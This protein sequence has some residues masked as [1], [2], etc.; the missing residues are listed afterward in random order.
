MVANNSDKFATALI[1]ALATIDSRSASGSNIASSS[2][3]TDTSTITFVAGFT[4]GSWIGDLIAS[5]FNSGLTGVSTTP[6]WV[7]SQTFRSYGTG[8]AYGCQRQFP[9]RTILTMK[10]GTAS[11]FTAAAMDGPSD[12]AARTGQADEAT[13]ANN[14]AYLRGDQSKEVGQTSGTLRKRTYPIGDIVD[15]S[16]AYVEEGSTKTVYIGANDGMLH[17]IDTD[18]GKVLFSYVPKGIDFTA[19][20]SLS[21][22][23]YD[24][25]YFVDG[26]IEVISQANQGNNKNILVG[27]LGRGGRGVFALDV[28]SPGSMGKN[29]VLWD[30]TTQDSTTNKNMGYV[31]GRVR[32]RKGNGDKTYAFVPNGMDSPNGS[33]T[34]FVYELGTGGGSWHTTKLVADSGGGN[35]LMSLGMADLNADGKVEWSTA[36]T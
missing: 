19:M 25:R 31:L 16:P 26:Q 12:F 35:G 28:T 4:S 30:N 20:A 18:T 17:G 23:A 7:L 33:A 22:T 11:L 15:S 13:A 32:I 21:A 6:D 36:A 9:S 24:H 34:L 3:K 29:Q 1:N 14:I 10:G 5:P 2:T 27:A 8:N